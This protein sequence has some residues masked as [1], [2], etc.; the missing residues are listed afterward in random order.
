M[1]KNFKR[2]L[3]A[4][5]SA[6]VVSAGAAVPVLA[7]DYTPLFA[8]D[9]VLN[10]WKFEFGAEGTTP[11]EGFTLVTPDDNYVGSAEGYGF[12][13]IDEESYKLGD[14]LDGFGNQKGQVIQLE[15]GENGG[16]GSVGED[17][18][19]NAGDTYYPV[20]FA[21][22]VEDEQY[23]RVRA[24]VTTLDPTKD[25]T[26]SLYTERKHPIYTEE[27]IPAG[28]E[29]TETFTI[30]TTP[31]Y[32][33]KSEPK[34]TIADEM[35]NVAVLGENTALVSLE[36]Q[37]VETAPVFWVL[38]DSTVTDGNCS[39]PFFPQQNFTGVGTGLTKY[40]PRNIA[41][42]NEGEG[43]LNAADNAHFNMV[44][45][46]IKAGD[47]MYVEYGHNHK[48]DGAA[49]YLT[50]LDK[51]YDACKAVGANLIIVS[52]IER[53]NTFSNGAYQYTLRS[54]AETGEAYVQEKVAAGATDIAY[55]DLNKFSLDFY[56][57]VTT[58]NGGD[59]NAIKYYFQTPKGGGTDITH[60][61]DQGAENLAYE[62][63]KAAQAVTDPA[64]KAVLDGFLANITAEEP[65][66]VSAEVMA[67]GI[68]GD[69]WPTYV[70][71]SDNQYPVVINDIQFNENGEA[72]YAKVTVQD[73][74][75]PL[76]T[77]GIIVITVNNPDGTEKGKIYAVDQVDNSTGN[78]TQEIVNFTTDV[79]LGENDTYTAQV[80]EAADT[81]D[82]LVAV[83]G[84]AIYSAV[85]TPTNIEKH[86]LLNENLDGAENFDYYGV[87][88]DGA[89]NQMTEKN[90]WAQIGSASISTYLNQTEDGMKYAEITSDGAKDGSAGQGSFYI[91][92]PLAENITGADGKYVISAD[93][94]Y[95]SGGG[96]TFNLLTGWGN[97]T[98]K[99]VVGQELFTV[100][101][102]GK[103]LA[104]GQEAGS[105]SAT[106]FTNVQ[107]I[108]DTVMG[109][110]SV[111]ISGGDPVTFDI[112]EYQTTDINAEF[113]T[114]T[115]FMF[116]GS[117]V[118]FDNRV[119]NL[120]VAKLKAEVL[121]EYTVTLDTSSENGTVSFGEDMPDGSTPAGVTME[122]IDGN[123][124]IT[125]NTAM[126]AELIEAAY[127]EDG[128][129]NTAKTTDVIFESAG[130][131][132]IPAA[133]GST[134]LLWNSLDGM[135]P[136]R[137]NSAE[138][139]DSIMLPIN[140]AVTVEAA[141]NP[142]YVFMGWYDGE[143]LMSMD[144][145]YT[146]RLRGDITLTPNFAYEPSVSDV[147]D[148]T[149]SADNAFIKAEAGNT[150]TLSVS[151]AVDAAGT[152]VSTVTNA[153][154][155]WTSSDA[156]IT[157]SA[158]GV[159]TVGDGF[160]TDGAS[161]KEVTITGTLNGVERTCVITF[162]NYAYYE[163]MTNANYNG[164]TMTI[165]DNSAIVFPGA[166][167]TNT[168]TLTEPVAIGAGTKITYSNAWSG[169]NT[170]GQNRTLNFKDS[171]G[172][173]IFSMYYSWA[174]LFV[175][176]TELG[177]A[178]SENTWTD[179]VIEIGDDG[180]TVT[181]TA[182]GNSATTTLAGSDLASIDF[183]SASSVPGPEARALGISSLIIE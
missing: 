150:T 170:C 29:K 80:V 134:L 155:A 85:Y 42:V 166:S 3:S 92:K 11:E 110:A 146:F 79:T 161:E 178:V 149:V 44:K 15:A 96:M 26:A 133:E 160:T 51:Y 116:G 126:T 78:G 22:D 113:K 86:L 136:I 49:G 50:H 156:N 75:T 119:A 47:Y 138:S 97:S 67:G 28:T 95:I 7:E 173:V 112:P 21:L 157:V 32:Y 23:F 41:M 125:S 17:D 179:V 58:D 135:T 152:P 117:K 105:V 176:G 164:L 90:E 131:Q 139:G 174:S 159:V 46:R 55:V 109:T 13:G 38:G 158:D 52:P 76:S 118:A 169:A 19:G 114:Y 165:A 5:L 36:I 129:L 84:G 82:G 94:Q 43:G 70:V 16:I 61:N 68:G 142:G 40:L 127:N 8:G 1:N 167:T 37:Q 56:N 147:V 123:V 69:A 181:V 101:D 89:T 154:V 2:L 151:G 12:L 93:I 104:D 24:T 103:I 83:E 87:T 107:C 74:V 53:I 108:L 137:I 66:L 14:R 102:S 120:T 60:P 122:Y 106:G 77:Y 168:Y 175:N 48:D 72:S 115:H 62:F 73:A 18:F 148:F 163:V 130:T 33:E 124:V 140:T 30:R 45:D 177:G 183:V 132:S 143:T 153:D 128:T 59:A 9:T 25:A 144:A 57:K 182:G 91:A 81:A 121:P 34:G 20:R 172:N 100:S 145:N 4:V 10:E 54:F 27:L 141:A 162:H 88:Y 39:L 6:A 35:V 171:S 31:I 65:N 98:S 99:I 64:Q 63:I 111:A 180:S 71:P